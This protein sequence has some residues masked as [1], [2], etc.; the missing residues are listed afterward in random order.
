MCRRD[1]I[2]IVLLYFLYI[3]LIRGSISSLMMATHVEPKHVA[4]FTCK[5]KLHIDCD[6]SFV[7]FIRINF[8]HAFH[9]PLVV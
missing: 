5:M 2:P 6:P 4:A 7:L 3:L 8:E 9:F 1:L